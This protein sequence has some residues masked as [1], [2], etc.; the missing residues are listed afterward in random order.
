[1][2]VG[3]LAMSCGKTQTKA[4]EL[5]R[6]TGVCMGTTWSAV[7]LCYPEAAA[8]TQAVIQT[9]LDKVD[10][11]LSTWKDDSDLSRI[12][13]AKRGE[14]TAIAN[15][16]YEV[17][18]ASDRWVQETGGA[19]DPTVGPLVALWGFASHDAEGV[20]PSPEAVGAALAKL[21]WSEIEITPAEVTKARDEISIDASAIAKGYSVDIAA[22]ALEDSGIN[23]FLLEVGG[24]VV[25]RGTRPGG[26][27]WRVAIND[28]LPPLGSDPA[29]PMKY[30]PRPPI[31]RIHVTDMAVATSGDYFNVRVIDGRTVTHAIDPRSGYPV[32]HALA[33]VTVIAADCASADALATAA[34]VLGADDALDLLERME[35]VE[36]L[37]LIRTP[38]AETPVAWRP[39][40]GLSKY[41]LERPL[42]KAAKQGR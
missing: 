5:H 1:M 19:F 20:A 35:N 13:R 17:L 24:E 29:S 37:L 34:L 15:V 30:A 21:G 3:A 27:S 7:V 33:S 39:T 9:E 32:D 16:T 4:P 36:G 8:T 28:P 40:S 6:I 26:E 31:A 10:A 2:V 12:A 22:D 18:A 41:R 11:A 25:V 14:P 42:D 23:D 38:E